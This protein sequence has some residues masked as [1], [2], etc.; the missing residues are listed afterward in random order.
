MLLYF[1]MV[2]KEEGHFGGYFLH[3]SVSFVK[4]LPRY[5]R[6]NLAPKLNVQKYVVGFLTI[7]SAQTL[8]AFS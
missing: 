8:E 2:I 5:F 4:K 6:S 1:E 3:I 7:A